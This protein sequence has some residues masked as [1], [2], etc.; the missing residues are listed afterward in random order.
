MFGTLTFS[1]HHLVIVADFD[2]VCV[3]VDEPKADT[4]LIVHGDGVLALAVSLERMEAIA[5]RYFQ[6]D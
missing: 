5:R 3:A 2:V 6:V 4:P 1:P